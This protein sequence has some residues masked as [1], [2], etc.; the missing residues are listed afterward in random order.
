[1]ENLNLLFTTKIS[2]ANTRCSSMC[3]CFLGLVAFI[4]NTM[5][6]DTFLPLFVGS[7]PTLFSCSAVQQQFNVLSTVV[8][9]VWA[10][11]V[12]FEHGAWGR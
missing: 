3:A 6:Y 4:T 1:M 10:V 8:M 11:I 5:E 9:I 12:M 7:L 2:S